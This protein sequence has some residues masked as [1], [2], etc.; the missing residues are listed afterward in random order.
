MS[1]MNKKCQDGIKIIDTMSTNSE[2]INTIKSTLA[3]WISPI[4]DPISQLYLVGGTV[5][6]LL[7]GRPPRDLD[8]VCPDP[9]TA[10]HYFAKQFEAKVVLFDT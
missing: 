4:T 7:L 5:R 9:E 8:M 10:A 1:T 3:K 6:D 2:I